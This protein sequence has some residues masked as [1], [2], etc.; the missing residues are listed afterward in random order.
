MNNDQ[1]LFDNLEHPILDEWID[2]PEFT[3]GKQEPY[4]K[5]IIRFASKEDLE[6]FSKMIDQ[7][8]TNK[9]KSIWHPSLIR[10]LNSTKRYVD[11]S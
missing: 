8:L 1:G 11:E 10:G 9:T 4:A 7:K 6:E 5:I 2:M 3:H